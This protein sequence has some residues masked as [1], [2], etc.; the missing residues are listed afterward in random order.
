M[1]CKD[2]NLAQ[3]EATLLRLNMLCQVTVLALVFCLSVVL[4]NISLKYIPVSFN[5]VRGS[6]EM[7]SSRSLR[8]CVST[9]SLRFTPP[10]WLIHAIWVPGTSA[11]AWML[12]SAAQGPAA[13][14]ES[15][16]CAPRRLSARR[17][18]CSQPSCRSLH[19]GSARHDGYM[20]R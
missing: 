4:G 1:S 6:C 8:T 9:L 14:A 5:Q 20:L 18:L 11:S 17:P 16:L 15:Q 12:D 2:T 13:L 3:A 10:H 19:W 7:L